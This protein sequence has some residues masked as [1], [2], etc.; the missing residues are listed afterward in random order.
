MAKTIHNS[1]GWLVMCPACGFGHLFDDG[2]FE[3]NGDANNPT[4]SPSMLVHGDDKERRCHSLVR[5]GTIEYL[6]DSAHEFAGQ[7][8]ALPEF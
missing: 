5:N 4:F 7:T 1:R 8:L 2:R 3:Y 6:K